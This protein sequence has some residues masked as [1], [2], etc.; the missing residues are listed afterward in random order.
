MLICKKHP[1][2][3]GIIYPKAANRHGKCECWYVFM[4]RQL[5]KAGTLAYLEE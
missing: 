4:V 1:K 3:K 2:Y 5:L